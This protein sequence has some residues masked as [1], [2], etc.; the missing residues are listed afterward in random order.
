M[1]TFFGITHTT[2]IKFKTGCVMEVFKNINEN[3]DYIK[4]EN[5]KPLS[6]RT[7]AYRYTL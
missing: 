2:S 6:A 4:K 3:V 5:N 1:Q 7:L